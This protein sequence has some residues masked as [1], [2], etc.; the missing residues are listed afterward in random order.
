[1]QVVRQLGG[2]LIY[3]LV[4][5]VLVVGGLSLALAEHT[6]STLHTPTS[7]LPA[8]PQTLTPTQAGFT[9]IPTWTAS[10][11]QTPLPPT[12][13]PP[14][15]GWTLV[16]VQPGDTL[17]SLAA[18][19]Q[20]TADQVRQGNCLLTS[21]LAVGYGIY[22]PYIP[23]QFQPTLVILCGPLPGW[24]RNYIV[25]PGDDLFRIALRYGT[26]TADLQRANCITNPNAIPV[27]L[28]LWVPNVPTITPGIT[29]IPEFNTQTEVPTEPLTLTPLPFTATIEPTFTNVPNTATSIPTSIP[30]TATITAFPTATP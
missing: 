9:E 18:R 21:S 23:P 28:Q 3:G 10:P 15:P 6:P 13:C 24:V 2:G 27:G 12:N 4:S 1:M 25:Q 11:T 22:V 14:P 5:V 7:S 30:P 17:E 20:T 8:A 29:Y 26:S 16:A 19:Y